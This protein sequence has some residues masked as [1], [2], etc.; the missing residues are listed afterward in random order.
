MKSSASVRG[1]MSDAGSSSKRRIS[2]PSGVPPGSRSWIA[3]RPRERIHAA[4]RRSCVVFPTPSAPSNTISAPRGM[5]SQNDDRARGSLLDPVEDPVVHL[6]HR[7]VEVLLG[8]DQPLI[9]A[10]HLHLREQRVEPLLHVRRGML[11][12]GD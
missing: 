5:S 8:H 12:A 1:V 7:L 9:H 6:P 2:S 11:T 3:L 10:L 4:T